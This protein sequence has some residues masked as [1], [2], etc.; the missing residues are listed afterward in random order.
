[1]QSNVIHTR[2]MYTFIQMKQASL[3]LNRN[4]N[5]KTNKMPFQNFVRV[6]FH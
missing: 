6:P 3:R 1:M 2:Y 4:S 5:L